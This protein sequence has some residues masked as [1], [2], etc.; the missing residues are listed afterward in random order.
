MNK[1]GRVGGGQIVTDAE[2]TPKGSARDIGYGQLRLSVRQLEAFRAFMLARTT[3]GAAAILGISQ[4]A[5]S[6][7]IEQLE[8][9]LR[10]ELFDRKNGRLVPTPEADIFFEEVERTFVS[11]D[12]ISEIAR[13]IQAARMGSLTV[14]AMPALAHAFLPT[15]IARFATRHPQA[16]ISVLVFP[17]TKIEEL[18]SAHHV[19]FGL[20]EFP[21]VRSGINAAEFCHTPYVLAMPAGHPLAALP[22]V[23]VTDL[24]GVPFISLSSNTAAR[25]AIDQ[26]FLMANVPL[27]QYYDAQNSGVIAGMI[28]QGLGVGLIDPFTARDFR[29]RGID[30]RPFEP[31]IPFRVGVLHPAHRPLSRVGREFLGMLQAIRKE[32]GIR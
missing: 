25:H 13:D 2:K 9:S 3:N 15:V 23:S 17:S 18:V 21:F 26:Q 30:V 4:P 1:R 28:A 16:R 20:G 10:F 12:K 6:R 11:V 24:A 22:Q 5:I 27:E 31:Q 32:W 14:A 8:R 29:G 7:L 19:D